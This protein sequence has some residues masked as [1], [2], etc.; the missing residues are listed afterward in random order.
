[1]RKACQMD[2]FTNESDNELEDDS[3]EEWSVGSF[4]EE[5]SIGP[6]EEYYP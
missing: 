6:S 5:W 4:D 1:M 3:D 2:H